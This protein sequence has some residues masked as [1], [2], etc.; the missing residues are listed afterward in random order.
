M[1]IMARKYE[2]KPDKSNS[3]FLSKLYLTQKQQHALVKWSVYSM[4]LLLLSVIQDVI[5]CRFHVYD[6]TTEL[7]PCAIFMICVLEGA[8]RGCIFVLLASLMYLFSGTAPGA[9]AMVLITVL[10]I[11]VSLLRQS[12]FQKSF[13]TCMLCTALAMFVYEL[14]VFGLGLFLELTTSS[15]LYV[16]CLTAVYSLVCMTVFYPI[17]TAIKSIGGESWKD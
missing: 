14:T 10:S 5:L 4:V 16:F 8:E 1:I 9:Y 2:F 7:V 12:Y 13:S 17:F 3:G 15:R 6:A 11:G